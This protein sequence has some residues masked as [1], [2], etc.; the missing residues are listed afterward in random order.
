MRQWKIIAVPMTAVLIASMGATPA[1]ADTPTLSIQN[2]AT[3]PVFS[4]ADA[5]KQTVFVEVAGTDSDSDGKPDR[6]AVDILR[7]KETEQGLKV[8][9]IMEAS[10]YYAGG[11]DSVPNHPVDVDADGNPEARIQA[12]MARSVPDVFPGYYDNYFVPRGYAI[13]LVENLGSGRATGCPTTG[14][15]NETEGPKAA[16]DWLNG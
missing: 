1:M 12:R 9:T 10:P 11:D 6:V 8:A 3:Q 5:I 13:V 16:I 4:R 14:D 7:P 15:R 2:N